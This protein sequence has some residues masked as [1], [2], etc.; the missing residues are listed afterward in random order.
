[1]NPAF[2]GETLPG[3]KPLKYLSQ[4]PV[5]ALAV[6]GSVLLGT[7]AQSLEIRYLLMALVLAAGWA[8]Y[9]LLFGADLHS[10]LPLVAV[11]FIKPLELSFYL[12]LLLIIFLGVAELLKSDNLKLSLPYP[13]A[14]FILLGFGI[15][16]AMRI[17]V[18]LGYS[19]FFSTVIVPFI[20][21]VLF[22]N[23]RLSKDSLLRWM[24][25]IVA[26][27]SFVALYGVLVAIRNPLE[28]L[29]SFWV[30]AMTINGFYTAAFFFAVTLAMQ[31]KQQLW[32]ALYSLAALVI[33]FGMLYTYTRMVILAVA[34]GMFLFMLK[35]KAMRYLGLVF[36]LLLPLVIPSSMSSRIQTGFSLDVSLVIRGLAWYLSAQQILRHPLFGL[37]FSVWSTWYP[38]VIPLRILYAQHSHNLF[39]NLM[40]D[41]GIV[42]TGAYLYIIWK[43]LRSFWRSCVVK[44]KDIIPY[45][46][47][48]AILSL[49]FACLTDIFIQ[50][51]SVSILFWIT[52]GLMLAFAVPAALFKV[53]YGE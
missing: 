39:L 42:G 30:T 35:I 47:F 11:F 43:L 23:A 1:M 19:Y 51:F 49:L 40:V 24:Q 2:P 36:A 20:V 26:V 8:V 46:L 16:S 4:I 34:F 15:Y 29:G 27:A 6:A 31:N 52:L 32:K 5:I 53:K 25:S 38:T 28:R 21:L 45:G 13:M 41:M 44:A 33:F 18:P 9:A 22:N 7:L 17:N 37:G 12:V 50:Q 48:V 14:F 10:S 3:K